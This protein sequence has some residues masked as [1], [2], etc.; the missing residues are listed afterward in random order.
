MPNIPEVRAE[1]HRDVAQLIELAESPSLSTATEVEAA[2]WTGM[3][4]LG[5][6]IMTLFFAHH[7]A[8]W[9]TGHRYTANGTLHEIIGNDAGELGTKFGKVAVQQPV[10]RAVGERRARRDRP[11]SR[12]LGLAGGFTLP[13]VTLVAKFCAMMAFA[14]TRQTLRDLLG[15]RRR[16]AP[17]F[18]WLM[19]WAPPHQASSTKRLF[20]RGTP[21]SCSSWL[22]GRV[23]LRSRARST[24]NDA[25]PTGRGPAGFVNARAERPRSGAG[26][27][28]SR[29]TRKWQ[30]SASSA[31]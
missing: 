4:R 21:T 6:S 3:L 26:Q 25:I 14:P 18:G 12:A 27:E 10:G 30:R 2:S 22:M 19:P 8:R 11:M 9:P 17:C 5:A 20:R 13:L 28:R 23:R 7:A 29:R 24:Q 1:I 16:L 31:P 15:G